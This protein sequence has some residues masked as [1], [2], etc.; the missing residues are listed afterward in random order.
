MISKT[1]LF[2]EDGSV[3]GLDGLSVDELIALASAAVVAGRALHR[4]AESV[5]PSEGIVY[6]RART[7]V[8]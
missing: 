1:I 3:S 5:E 4:V 7:C 6:V 2:T 8:G